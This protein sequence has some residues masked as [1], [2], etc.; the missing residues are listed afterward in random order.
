MSQIPPILNLQESD[1]IKMLACDVHIGSDNL[2]E[3]MKRYV[4]KRAE[5]G[6]H[7]I[8]LRK[9]WEKL[10]LAARV[11]VAIE[12]PKDICSVA[13]SSVASGPPIAQ[14]AVL[15]LAKYIGCRTIVGRITPGTFTNYQQQNYFEPRLLITS[16]PRKDYQ[17]IVEASYVNMPV[18]SFA[19]TNSSLRGVDI[20]IPCNTE[21]KHSVALMYYLLAREV[22]RLLDRAPRDKD[23]DIM[24]DMFV[25][26]DAEQEHEKQMAEEAAS[27]RYTGYEGS[28]AL[29]APA[30]DEWGDDHVEGEPAEADFGEPE[31]QGDWAGGAEWGQDAG[32]T[33]TSWGEG[34]W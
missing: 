12:N 5:T 23:W 19:N 9:T 6:A 24:V 30:G 13:L 3:S 11:I 31:A 2:N 33:N 27:Q 17:P 10:Q 26:R 8:D 1:V 34:D 7:I 15:K 16:D 32:P 28:T 25:Y 18:I 21:G 29:E 14:R 20:A 4:Y 22:L